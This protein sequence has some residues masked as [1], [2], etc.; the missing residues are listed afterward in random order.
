MSAVATPPL[1]PCTRT[2]CPGRSPDRTNSIRYAV[3]QAVGRHA[4]SAKESSAGLG[5]TF[6][7][8]T[9]TFSAIVPWCSSLNR[10]RFGSS[11]SSPVQPG[12]ATTPWT[13]TSLP[14]SSRPAASVPRI[15]GIRSSGR[16][17]PR[18]L[19]RSWWLS[20]TALTCTVVQPSGTSGSG[21][22]PISSTESGSF[23]AG[24]ETK[25][26]SML[27]KLTNDHH[28]VSAGDELADHRGA[29]D[30]AAEQQPAG[31]LRV[32]EQQGLVLGDR[33]QVGVRP[34]PVEVA[35]GPA[36]DEPGRERLP[37]PG[38]VGDG[39]GVDDRGDPAGPGHLVEVAEQPEAGDVGAGADARGDGGPAGVP[40]ERGHRGDGLLGHLA[41]LL[42]PAVEY[43]DAERLG[44]GQRRAGHRGVVADD[45]LDVDQAGD[46][47]AV[48]G[49]GVVDRVAA[50]YVAA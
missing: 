18:R 36:G 10:L 8:G 22:S 40:V 7:F 46:R 2:V 49:L 6:R 29:G 38:Q 37:R 17:T 12:L 48:L 16:P 33:R 19:N 34:H 5:S 3:S 32:G 21:R 27:C 11:V 20:E 14:S 13:T 35:T 26:A 23:G 44:Q 31:G 41:G 50:A 1:A 47:H 15:I 30:L 24:V 45:P 42:E 39:G 9:A 43:A 28:G 25:A 4:A